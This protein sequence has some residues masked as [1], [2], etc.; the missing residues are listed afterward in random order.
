MSK[1]H[2]IDYFILIELKFCLMNWIELHTTEEL[3]TLINDSNTKPAII[4]KNSTTCFIS[5]MALRNFEAEFANE[6]GVDCY[7]IDVKKDRP[8]SMEVA[9][10]F[11]VQHE[12]PQLLI[13]NKGLVTY[14]TSHE[15]IDAAVTEK[16]L[17]EI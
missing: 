2:I 10:R 6:N 5:K 15:G 9:N 8:L 17:T 14:T 7:M 4:F 12:S 3:D 16:K 13:V 1:R 11:K